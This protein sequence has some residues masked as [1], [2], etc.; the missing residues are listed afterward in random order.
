MVGG[1]TCIVI[2]KISFQTLEHV[3]TMKFGPSLE[4]GIAGNFKIN[5][6]IFNQQSI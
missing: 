5:D 4:G 6:P 1:D 3:V 2:A